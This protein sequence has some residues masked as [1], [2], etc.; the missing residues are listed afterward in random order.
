MYWVYGVSSLLYLFVYRVYCV[1]SLL[2]LFMYRVYGV[3]SLLY[4]LFTGFNTGQSIK[5]ESALIVPVILW[6]SGYTWLQKKKGEMKVP[7]EDRTIN[8]G[9]ILSKVHH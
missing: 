7:D 5:V 9:K 2:Y 4:Y 8:F 6:G 3:S 1:S